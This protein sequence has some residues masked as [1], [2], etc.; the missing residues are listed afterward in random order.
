MLR[1]SV[2]CDEHDSVHN[3]AKLPGV[4]R[5]QGESHFDFHA[6]LMLIESACTAQI[7][8][9]GGGTYCR[10]KHNELFLF[11]VDMADSST[12]SVGIFDV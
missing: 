7:A 11:W 9:C 4:A 6:F 2:L 1:L 3:I 12:V 8:H 10:K 5:L